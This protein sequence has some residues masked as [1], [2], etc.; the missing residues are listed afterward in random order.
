MSNGID[1]MNRQMEEYIEKVKDEF[2][3]YFQENITVM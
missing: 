2:L 1:E 3:Y